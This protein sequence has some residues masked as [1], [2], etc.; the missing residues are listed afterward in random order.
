MADCKAPKLVFPQT[1]H[2][3]VITEDRRNMH[4]VIETVLLGLGVTAPLEKANSSSGGKFVSFKFTV[5]VA[6]HE[7]MDEIDAQLRLIE[8]VR[9]VL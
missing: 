1:C 8:G 4:F 7:M 3:R 9:M 5:E 6:S 2:F